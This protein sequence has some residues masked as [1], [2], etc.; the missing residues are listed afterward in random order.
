RYRED[1]T[2]LWDHSF[3]RDFGDDADRIHREQVWDVW[4]DR[5]HELIREAAKCANW[6]S[7]L[8]RAYINPYFRLRDGYVAD[9]NYLCRSATTIFAG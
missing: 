9:D 3:Y 8:I 5:E 4:V 1:N 2:T 7:D 6:V